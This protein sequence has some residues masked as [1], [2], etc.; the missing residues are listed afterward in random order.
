M[1][2]QTPRQN[3]YACAR[4]SISGPFLLFP[5][6]S[7][8]LSKHIYFRS[9]SHSTLAY[10]YLACS[11]VSDSGEDARVKGTR[12]VSSL[13]LFIY[14]LFIYLFIFTFVLSEFS[15]PNYLGAG[16]R[17]TC[18]PIKKDPPFLVNQTVKCH[19]MIYYLVNF[20]SQCSLVVKYFD[21]FSQL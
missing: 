10:L 8:C 1:V 11:R 12:K 7:N 4:L 5:Q 6:G 18:N 3:V 13:Y 14:Y 20:W 15:E 2:P 19:A 9:I 16:N 21:L 17:L